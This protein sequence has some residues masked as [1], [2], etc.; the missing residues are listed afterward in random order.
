MPTTYKLYQ[1]TATDGAVYID[2]PVSGKITSISFTGF[3]LAGAGGIGVAGAEVSR[4]ASNQFTTSNPR[5]V[6][7]AVVAATIAASNGTHVQHRFETNEPIKAGERLYLNMNPS[8][9]A[10]TA[11][12]SMQVFI[13]VS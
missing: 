1:A 10:N 13:T 8:F 4:Q 12:W 3:L 9:A 2:M 5:G 6:I 11:T 7:A